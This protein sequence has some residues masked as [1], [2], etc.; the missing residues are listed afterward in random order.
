MIINPFAQRLAEQSLDI[1]PSDGGQFWKF[2]WAANPIT[3]GV[4]DS[5]CITVHV[6]YNG[7]IDIVNHIDDEN[8]QIEIYDFVKAR[9]ERFGIDDEEN[10]N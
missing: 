9:Y 7:V 4:S 8:T 10:W 3:T 5:T 6:S 1:S 2:M